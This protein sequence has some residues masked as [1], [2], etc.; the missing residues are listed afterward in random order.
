VA[1][2]IDTSILDEHVARFNEGVRTGDFAA[3][4]N[5]FTTDAVMTFEGVPVGPFVGRDAI[6]QAY[7]EQPPDDEILILGAPAIEGG[8]IVADYAWAAA[9][10]RAGRML[11]TPADGRVARLTVTFE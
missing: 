5:A 9:G 6:S 3:M 7:A 2:P 11:L 8:T 1:A 10:T 4:L